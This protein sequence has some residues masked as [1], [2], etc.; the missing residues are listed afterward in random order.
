MRVCMVINKTIET[1]IV[2]S[3]AT[4]NWPARDMLPA[5]HG[6]QHIHTDGGTAIL[7]RELGGSI[8]MANLRHGSAINIFL[9][10]CNY[11]IGTVLNLS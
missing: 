1:S 4:T 9:P 10:I 2:V 5:R 3:V 7:K 8:I 11:S 6:T